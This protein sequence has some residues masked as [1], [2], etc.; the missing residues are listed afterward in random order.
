MPTVAEARLSWSQKPGNQFRSPTWLAGF[1]LL[2]LKSLSLRVWPI[3]SR[4]WGRYGT[5]VL[6]MGWGWIN[7]CLFSLSFQI[8]KY[9][10]WKSYRKR[11]QERNLSFGSFKMALIT[12]ARRMTGTELGDRSFIWVSHVEWP[13]HLGCLLFSQGAWLEVEQPGYKTASI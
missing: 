10:I 9:F 7:Q 2:E 5:Q 12:G 3:G 1:Q 8:F 13:K 6:H 11:E 4:S